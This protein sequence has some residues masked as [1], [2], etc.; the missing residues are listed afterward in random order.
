MQ[1]TDVLNL[2]RY[3]L[4]SGLTATNKLKTVVDRWTPTNTDTN[5]PRAGSTIRRSTGIVNDV[6][7]DGSFVRLK[8]VTLGYTLPKFSKVIKSA[9]VYVTAQNLVT[10]TDY[11]GY[12]PEVNSFGSD[13]LSLNTDYNAF[14]STRTFIAGLRLGF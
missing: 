6:L 11:S 5:I 13:N 4:E 8:T 1:G 7:E 9:N 12:D 10:W 3:E 14:P 2:N